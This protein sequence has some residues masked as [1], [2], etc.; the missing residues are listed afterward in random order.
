M[1]L[2]E[3]IANAKSPREKRACCVSGTAEYHVAAV[4][5]RGVK[6]VE[7]RVGERTGGQSGRSSAGPCK[8]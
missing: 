6:M 3:G 5:G 2:G 4:E 7:N 1:A 8:V